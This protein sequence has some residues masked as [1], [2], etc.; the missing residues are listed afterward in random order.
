MP[1]RFDRARF[2]KALGAMGV[3]AALGPGLV[4]ASAAA[5]QRPTPGGPPS[6]RP[7]R[8]G[9]AG[10]SFDIVERYRPFALLAEG[11]VELDDPFD[12]DSRSSYEVLSPTGT[13]GAVIVGG[14]ALRI[15]GATAH[16]TLL[17]SDTRQVAPFATVLVDV[18][19]TSGSSSQDAVVAG[20]VQDADNAVLV[21]YD[22]ATGEAAVEVLA[23]GERRVL[24]TQAADL[25]APYQF[26]FVVNE[27]EVVALADTG[28]GPQP[29]I[30]RNVS[31]VVDLRSQEVLAT[32]H[33]AVGIRSGGGGGGGETVIGGVRAGYWGQ[34]GVRDPHTVTD[35]DGAPLIRDNQLYLTLTQSGLGFF[36][37]AHWGVWTL[38]LD[39]YE[40]RQVANLFFTR[41]DRGLV[42]GDHAG[43]IVVDGD[44]FIVAN[45][46]WGDFGRDGA[47]VQ[48][49]YTATEVDVLAGVHVLDTR[50][51]QLPLDGLPSAAAGQWDPHIVRIRGR[52]Y[53]A[54]VNARVFFD[55]YPALAA[56][57]GLESLEFVGADGGKN[58][59]EGTVMQKLGGEWYLLTSSGDT[60]VGG[61][62]EAYPVYDLQMRFVQN[63]DAPHPTN[64]PWPMVTPIPVGPAET[65]YILT[66]FNTDQ[67]REDFLGYGTHGDFFVMEAEQTARGAEFPPRR[68]RFPR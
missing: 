30:R 16:D 63:L 39:S 48:V 54:F 42:F 68:G 45:S 41:D 12:T 14:G 37:Q 26:A 19:A 62:T 17:R 34:A 55:F 65:R 1:E 50:P 23:D 11:F 67:Y 64:I 28:D 38:D 10:L 25:V 2:L 31:E 43:H 61:P 22:R 21:S 6:P 35:L 36:Q 66:T 15:D 8:P 56:G 57:R 33:N 9:L 5:Q 24:G 47:A 49:N 29:L 18:V 4:S 40:L 27:N 46:T 7:G 20:L 13:P 52:W 51:M 60:E 53:V 58:Q 3:G 32:H 44:R 59:T